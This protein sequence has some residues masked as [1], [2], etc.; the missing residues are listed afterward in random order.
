MLKE[1]RTF[2]QCTRFIAKGCRWIY[3]GDEEDDEKA[4]W[5]AGMDFLS[6]EEIRDPSARK[7]R[8]PEA[9]R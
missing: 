5:A 2:L 9:R 4:A 8:E 7:R 6:A 3:V 1:A